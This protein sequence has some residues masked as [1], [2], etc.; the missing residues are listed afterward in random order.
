M[1]EE[2]VSWQQV[3]ETADFPRKVLDFSAASA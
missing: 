1:A 2:S 3:G